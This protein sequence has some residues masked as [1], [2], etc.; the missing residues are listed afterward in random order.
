MVVLFM[1]QPGS[2]IFAI[3]TPFYHL[4][5]RLALGELR[6]S[7]VE[8]LYVDANEPPLSLRREKLALQ[9]YT[10]LQ[11][12]PSNPAFDCTINP[13][14][15]ECFARKE[16]AIPTFVIRIQSLLDDNN[17]ENNNIHKTII[18]EVSPWT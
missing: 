12:C 1:G 8:S 4:G 2:L 11:S 10:T 13:K 9:Y 3:L 7:P 16:S 17:I 15:E 14:Y 5:L 6:T 18:S